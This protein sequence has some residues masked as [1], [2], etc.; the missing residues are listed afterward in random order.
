MASASTWAHS[1]I[2][3]NAELELVVCAGGGGAVRVACAVAVGG[4]SFPAIQA[5]VD[6]ATPLADVIR[7][8][9]S[10]GKAR[11]RGVDLSCVCVCVCE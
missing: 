2:S 1:G 6:A 8:W 11:P 5:S 7:G 3:N 9:A 10:E 4:A